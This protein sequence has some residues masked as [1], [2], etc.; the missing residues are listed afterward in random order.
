MKTLNV[1]DHNAHN[2]WS[3]IKKNILFICAERLTE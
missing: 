2:T 3:E 1:L